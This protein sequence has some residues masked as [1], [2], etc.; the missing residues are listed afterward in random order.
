MAVVLL[1]AA[2][3][4]LTG[5]VHTGATHHVD[6]AVLH[7]FAEAPFT[8]TSLHD[9]LEVVVF[10]GNAYL[11]AALIAAGCLLLAR[12]GRRSAALAYAL[13]LLATVG[14]ELA[15]K[16]V[17]TQISFAPP[18]TILGISFSSFPSG[19]M[20]R[21]TLLA[22]LAATL[23]PRAR[24]LVGAWLLAVP[25]GI[26]VL[27]MHT[28]SDVCGG[29]L[30][31]ASLALLSAR[32]ERGALPLRRSPRAPAAAPRRASAVAAPAAQGAKRPK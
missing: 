19:H 31:G 2:F 3:V 22:A 23:L 21:C 18:E 5:L 1:L 32:A 7:R 8:S 11:S 9:A 15:C 13:A 14:V 4:A 27:R 30:L 17:V 12:R 16:L 20:A 6:H 26:V 28:L 29:A 25:V 10:P 24:P